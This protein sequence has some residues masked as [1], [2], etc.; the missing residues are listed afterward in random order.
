M[1]QA[2]LDQWLKLVN[3]ALKTGQPLAMSDPEMLV[4]WRGYLERELTAMAD[5]C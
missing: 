3:L 5:S 1:E 2:K 4:R